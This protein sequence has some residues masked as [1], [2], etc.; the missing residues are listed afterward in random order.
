[1]YLVDDMYDTWFHFDICTLTWYI[2]EQMLH[3]EKN[4]AY[5][6]NNGLES[7]FEIFILI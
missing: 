7:W 5:F 3:I 4:V 1:M 6:F 2:D